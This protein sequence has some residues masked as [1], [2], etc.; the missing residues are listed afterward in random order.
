[1]QF[2][3]VV[4][5]GRSGTEMISTLLQL[6][7]RACVHHEPHEYD[8]KI[9]GLRRARLFDQAL[10]GLL[11]SRFDELISGMDGR[12][13][14]YGEVNSYLRY[15]TDWLTRRFSAPLV[16]IYRDGRE[17]VRSSY[18]RP[19]YTAQDG[20][21][22]I[23][24][25]NDDPAARRWSSMTRF[26]KLCW[27][28]NHTNSYLADHVPAGGKME[29]A[30]TEYDYFHERI[31]EPLGLEVPEESWSNLVSRPRNTSSRYNREQLIR[32]LFSRTRRA[33]SPGSIPH[34]SKWNDE[35]TRQFWSI[36]GDTMTRLG[37]T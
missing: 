26:E 35:M 30:L 14:I 25:C 7:Q 33:A 13:E 24:P 27:Y 32:R 5:L 23:L 34:W 10:D 4:A 29:R 1:M 15:E 28:W 36:C 37:Y 11:E 21:L 6:D 31:L 22:P 9:V 20:N 17:F 19:V 18:S 16:R 8:A 2:F 3:F 12:Y